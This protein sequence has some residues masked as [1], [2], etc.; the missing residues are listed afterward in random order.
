M[1]NVKKNIVTL[2]EEVGGHW[3]KDTS[4]NLCVRN[5]V[6]AFSKTLS[7]VLLLNINYM[8]I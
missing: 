7:S 2:F 6:H 1:V 8:P 4:N 5:W 3:K